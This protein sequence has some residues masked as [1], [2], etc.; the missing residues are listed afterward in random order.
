MDVQDLH[1]A[2]LNADE[3]TRAARGGQMTGSPDLVQGPDHD[4]EGGCRAG[5]KETGGPVAKPPAALWRRSAPAGAL[6]LSPG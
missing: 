3:N 6:P 5:G 1:D 4:A 2:R